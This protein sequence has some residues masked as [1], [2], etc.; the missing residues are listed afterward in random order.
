MPRPSSPTM[1]PQASRNSTSLLELERLPTLSLRR[2]ISI[3]FLLPS[4]RQ[5]G[6]KKQEEPASVLA[7]TRWASDIGEEKNHL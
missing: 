4:G 7:S 5:R 1:T 3:G 2:W 6:T